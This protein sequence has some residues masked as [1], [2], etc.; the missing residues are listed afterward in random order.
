MTLE[1]KFNLRQKR[2]TEQHQFERN[3]EL[4]CM[5]AFIVL[6]LVGMPVSYKICN[7]TRKCIVTYVDD[8]NKVIGVQNIRKS[9]DFY[10][11]YY[12]YNNNVSQYIKRGDTLKCVGTRDTKKYYF[13]TD[14]IKV[15]GTKTKKYFEQQKQKTR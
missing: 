3:V 15:N 14:V 11:V 9:S 7:P 10:T 5:C 6:F 1:E 2:N 12:G 8:L 13:D 4:G